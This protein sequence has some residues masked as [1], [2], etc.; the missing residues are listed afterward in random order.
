MPLIERVYARAIALAV[1]RPEPAKAAAELWRLARGDATVLKGARRRCSVLVAERPEYDV[2][3][4]ALSSL[5]LA[6]VA[7]DVT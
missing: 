1:E 6:A 4:R 2:A 5:S 3:R 7:L